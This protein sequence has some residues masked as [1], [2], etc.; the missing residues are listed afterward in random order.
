MLKIMRLLRMWFLSVI[1]ISISQTFLY[2]DG[3]EFARAKKKPQVKSGTGKGY[4]CPCTSEPVIRIPSPTPGLEGPNRV[5]RYFPHKQ[6]NLLNEQIISNGS[7]YMS[8]IREILTPGLYRVDLDCPLVRKHLPENLRSTNVRAFVFTFECLEEPLTRFLSVVTYD[9][10]PDKIMGEVGDSYVGLIE[11][12]GYFSSRE[13]VYVR[14]KFD[15]RTVIPVPVSSN[16]TT[17]KPEA[18]T[19]DKPEADTTDKPEADTTDKPEADVSD[20]PEADMTDKPEADMTDKP[21]ADM[22]D[23]PEA[24]M[25]DKPEADMTDKPEADM[26]DKPEADVSDKPEADVSDKP[27]ADMT[28]KPEADESD[29]PEAD[30]VKGKDVSEILSGFTKATTIQDK[31]NLL[32][33]LEPDEYYNFDDSC[34]LQLVAFE[35]GSDGISLI[36]GKIQCLESR[37][38][39]DFSIEQKLSDG[40]R[41]LLKSLSYGNTFQAQLKFARIEITDEFEPYPVWSEIRDVKSHTSTSFT[42]RW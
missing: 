23:K 19:T 9:R 5:I 17:D 42:I 39:Y 20:K 27:E 26:P 37:D 11:V 1:L 34:L 12:N 30:K 4:A 28:D 22:T 18:D 3:L 14:W 6:L 15:S 24:D 13:S 40:D 16:D 8:R 7:N 33:D 41:A 29:K 25:P 31:M 36:R 21:E 2:A 38:D 35:E 10:S 32:A